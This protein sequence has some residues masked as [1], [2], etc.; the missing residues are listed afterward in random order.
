MP[1]LIE[2]RFYYLDN[3][4]LVLNWVDQRYSDLLIDEEQA[5]IRDF[6]SLPQVSQALLVR[7][8]MRK[9]KLFRSSKLV[10]DEIGSLG[11]AVAPLVALGWVDNNPF[12]SVDDLFVL[13]KKTEIPHIF[14][15]TLPKKSAKKSSQLE[16]LRKEMRE[17]SE[18]GDISDIHPF[19]V[20]W[21]NATECVYQVKVCTICD[22]L[23]LLF[24]GNL[25]QSWTE[26]VLADLGI[27]QYEKVA[28]SSTSRGFQKRQE[29]EDYC[30]LFQCRE[31]FQ[32]GESADAVINDIPAQA[33][34]SLLLE[35]RRTRLLFQIAQHYEKSED[36][37]N[38]LTVYALSNYQGARIRTIRIMERRGQLEAAF[39]LAKIAEYAPENE[40]EKQRLL[41]VIPRLMRQ[42]GHPKEAVASR[43]LLN[44]MTLT[45]QKP[46]QQESVEELARE[47][48]Q[49]ANAPQNAQVH[50]VENGLINSLFGLLCW[51]VIFTPIPNAFFHPFHTGPADLYSADFYRRREPQFKAS[52]QQLDSDQYAET[53]RQRFHEKK[54]IQSPF[55]FWDVLTAELLELALLCVPAHHLKCWFERILLDI[56]ANRAGIPDLIQFWPERKQYRLIEVKGPGD[57]LQDNQLRWF[58]YFSKHNMPAAVCY[59]EWTKELECKVG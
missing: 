26:F 3:F 56:K 7:M 38:A 47:Y 43:V 37:V 4:Q 31:R 52:L 19:S 49:L 53:I 14:G 29:I 34:D 9:G 59:V 16:A 33:Y 35:E 22:H 25:R 42:L 6:S 32:Q 10:Y 58:D 15:R 2:N 41:R 18:D 54:G 17:I 8:V 55:V 24:F 30:H 20:W 51:D 39:K 5:F 44:K 13:L 28:F 21:P 11:A 12:L 23:R 50:Y 40:E 45:L 1:N 27:F 57:R 48:L 36:L 46:S